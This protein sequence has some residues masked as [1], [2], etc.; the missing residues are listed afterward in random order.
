MEA[1][2]PLISIVIPCYNAEPY[3]GAAIESALRQTHEPTEVIVIDDGST[4]G[5]LGAIRSFRDQITWRSGKNNGPSAA[6]NQ[7]LKLASGEFVKFLDA[8]DVL[9][10]DTVRTQVEQARLLSGERAIVFGDA[11]YVDGELN[12]QERTGFRSRECNE[13]PIVYILKV[14]PQ[15]SL[16]LHRR[17][18]LAEVDGFDERLRWAED[19]DLHLRLHLAGI[20]LHYQP[21]E[22]TQ[23]RRHGGEDRL[24]NRKASEDGWG[25]VRRIERRVE[26]IRRA[27][28]LAEPVRRILAQGSWHVGRSQ[29]RAGRPDIA[30]ECFDRARTLHPQ[31]AAHT[32][33][34][35]RWCVRLFGPAAAERMGAWTRKLNRQIRKH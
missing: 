12:V 33:R 7:G 4:D 23:V 1:S 11:H 16:P 24:T 18:F 27:G 8:D 21:V 14:N 29:L 6:R 26:M 32:S 2:R 34:A 10:E 28:K 20:H 17:E 13:D 22:V 35:Y 15:T 30:E 5:S 19:Y 31:C 3:V 25:G 9:L